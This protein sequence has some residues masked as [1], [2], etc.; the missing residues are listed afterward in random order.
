MLRSAPSASPALRRR[1]PTTF[2]AVLGAL[3]LT[4]CGASYETTKV[5]DYR[6]TLVSG[7]ADLKDEFR[8]LI[9]DYNRF[10]GIQALTW[11]NDADDANSAIV[12]TKGLKLQDGHHIGWGQWMSDSEAE[13]PLTTPG[14]KPK[15]QVVY[16]MRVEFDEDW[17]R[18]RMG[19]D[20][21]KKTYE[22]Q[23]LFFHE[24]GHGLEL[25]H[26]SSPRDVMYA[27]VSG[28]KDFVGYFDYVRDY[29]GDE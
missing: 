26:A 3:A 14:R 11:V 29:L 8:K 10:A 13:N 17:I 1:I 19:H 27:E 6:M 22:N 16:S 20:D 23:K 7:D 21:V 25:S 12:V 9:D 5:K 4:A 28:D 24:V 15:R 2:F 18:A